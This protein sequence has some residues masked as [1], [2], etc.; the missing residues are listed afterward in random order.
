[1]LFKGW[2]LVTYTEPNGDTSQALIEV[3]EVDTSTLASVISFVTW[4]K[5]EDWPRLYELNQI[6]EGAR[7]EILD[8]I[9]EGFQRT[10]ANKTQFRVHVD[11]LLLVPV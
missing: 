11:Q 6:R 5:G 4:C 10:L 3:G 9:L 8:K 1:M 7:K 2:L